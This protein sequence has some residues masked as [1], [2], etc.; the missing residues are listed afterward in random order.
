MK[1]GLPGGCIL[2]G[3]DSL[4]PLKHAGESGLP[5]GLT[6]WSMDFIEAEIPGDGLPGAYEEPGLIRS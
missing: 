3:R 2:K 6:P 5:R 1:P 4:E